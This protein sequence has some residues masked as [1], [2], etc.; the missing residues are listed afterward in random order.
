MNEN[1]R[2]SFRRKLSFAGQGQIKKENDRERERE[3]RQRGDKNS[4]EI[5]DCKRP[6]NLP[7]KE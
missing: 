6:D 3:E 2:L 5:D 4:K 1:N 7:N